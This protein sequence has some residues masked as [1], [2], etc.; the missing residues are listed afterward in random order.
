MALHRCIADFQFIPPDG[1]DGE[2][3][4]ST[5][6][7]LHGVADHMASHHK[8]MAL[9]LR[10]P[11]PGGYSKPWGGYCEVDVTVQNASARWGN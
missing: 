4:R 11:P 1:G 3:Q 5:S 8:A 2:K 6:D 9:E 10:P 7:G